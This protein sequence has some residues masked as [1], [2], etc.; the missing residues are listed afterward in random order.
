[1]EGEDDDFIKIRPP[2]ATTSEDKGH[3]QRLSSSNPK[4]DRQVFVSS[5]RRDD[6]S[7]DHRRHGHGQ[8]ES[9]RQRSNQDLRNRLNHRSRGHRPK[10]SDRDRMKNRGPRRPQGHSNQPPA[11]R[12]SHKEMEASSNY[13]RDERD[14]RFQRMMNA[15]NAK[16]ESKR[17]IEIRRERYN[18][19]FL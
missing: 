7:Q 1:M 19:V 15:T 16:A 13:N 8:G 6:R 9:H 2:Q 17:D 10:E 18:H 12:S 11:S 5:G 4:R 3:R 14:L